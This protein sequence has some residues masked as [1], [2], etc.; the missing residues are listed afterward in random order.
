VTGAVNCFLD[1]T[2]RKRMDTALE[3]SRLRAL[4]R[5]QCCATYEHARSAYRGRTRRPLLRVN[6][7]ICAIAGMTREEH[8]A[9]KLFDHT[10]PD[11]ADADAKAS[12]N[13]SRQAQFYSSK[14]G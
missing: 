8:L 6:E 1:V 4:E 3:Q 14:S 2:E 9:T 11:D 7:A 13:R 12:A 5:E 10:H